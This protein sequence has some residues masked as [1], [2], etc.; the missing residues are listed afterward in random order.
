[1][2]ESDR[3]QMADPPGERMIV[4]R[5]EE[6]IS[7]SENTR[8]SCNPVK[9]QRCIDCGIFLVKDSTVMVGNGRQMGDDGNGGRN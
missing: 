7:N 5:K 3:I 2:R 8:C 9:P 6:L 4:K 1:M